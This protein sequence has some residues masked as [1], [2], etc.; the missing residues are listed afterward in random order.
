[1]HDSLTTLEYMDSLYRVTSSLINSRSVYFQPGQLAIGPSVLTAIT[2]APAALGLPGN[3]EIN[4]LFAGLRK[5]WQT[6][7][8]VSK[9]S[10]APPNGR[11]ILNSD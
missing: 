6:W 1:M 3:S 11:L 7:A 2:Q 8:R 5:V 4:Q 9:M 10:N